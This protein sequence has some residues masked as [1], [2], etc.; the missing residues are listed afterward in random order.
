M[1]LETLKT[2]LQNHPLDQP[3]ALD[4]QAIGSDEIMAL[5]RDCLH[6]EELTIAE[7]QIVPAPTTIT[8]RV[9][10]AGVAALLEVDDLDVE[11]EFSQDA[12]GALQLRLTARL[13]GG[14]MFGDSFPNAAGYLSLD[15]LN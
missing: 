14:W 3:L 10:I 13:P 1:T 6:I 8:D 7:P 2:A 11:A 15:P 5:L 12:G 4:A 9:T